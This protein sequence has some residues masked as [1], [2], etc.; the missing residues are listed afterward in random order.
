[1]KAP[2]V[3]ARFLLGLGGNASPGAGPL[4]ASL[5]AL[6]ERGFRLHAVSRLYRSPALGAPEPFARSFVNAAALLEGPR[7]PWIV[8]ELLKEF[9]RR[10]GRDPNGARNA[11]RPLDLDLLAWEGLS[12]CSPSLTLPHPRIWGRDFVLRPL[13][14]LPEPRTFFPL[15]LPPGRGWPCEAVADSAWWREEGALVS[16]SGLC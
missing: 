16:G 12:C 7:D 10:A 9:E 1:M 11:S 13:G 15:G 2:R 4:A 14:D 6:R 8:L 3:P 5:R